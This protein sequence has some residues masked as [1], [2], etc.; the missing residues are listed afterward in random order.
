MKLNW[1]N[2]SCDD[3]R[4]V[5]IQTS[6]QTARKCCG[7]NSL[8]QMQKKHETKQPDFWLRYGVLCFAVETLNFQFKKF[9]HNSCLI[10]KKYVC[11]QWDLKKVSFF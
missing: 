3:E 1:L 4:F 2:S 5:L 11:L 8:H 7:I 10:K 9:H 6:V